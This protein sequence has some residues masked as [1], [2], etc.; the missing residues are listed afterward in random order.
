MRYE[1]PI[2]DTLKARGIF[3]E[4]WLDNS[5]DLLEILA[6]VWN[7]TSGRPCQCEQWTRCL[8]HSVRGLL[9]SR[10]Q[11]VYKATSKP[12]RPACVILFLL[13]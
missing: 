5:F 12:P 11:L 8:S 4:T 9:S 2:G 3:L 6:K 10:T 7:L 1:I 13:N